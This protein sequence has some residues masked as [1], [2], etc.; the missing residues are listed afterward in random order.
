MLSQFKER[1]TAKIGANYG[2]IFGTNIKV[3]DMEKFTPG[4]WYND[5]LVQVH[6]KFITELNK[7][8]LCVDTHFIGMI[9]GNPSLLM[10]RNFTRDFDAKSLNDF[11][12]V[13]IPINVENHWVLIVL[14]VQ[15]HKLFFL[16][17]LSNINEKRGHSLLTLVNNFLQANFNKEYGETRW[18]QTICT[19]QIR[20]DNYVDCGVFVCYYMQLVAS[21]DEFQQEV[22]SK[23][24]N[25]TSYREEMKNKFEQKRS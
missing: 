9:G 1:A 16:D 15:N 13:C 22:F 12:F 6:G 5:T 7:N 24:F 10:E 25:V 21:C 23:P 2:I 19:K 14:D 17:S 20:Q 4:T 11:H 18:T 3:G 8:I